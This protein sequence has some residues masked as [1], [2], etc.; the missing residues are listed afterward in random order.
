[1]T[2]KHHR[3]ARLVEVP[4]CSEQY[5]QSLPL[6]KSET[7]KEKSLLHVF[8][9]CLLPKSSPS[10]CFKILTCIFPLTKTQKRMVTF[11]MQMSTTQI[12]SSAMYM[13][14][15]P[16]CTFIFAVGS[17]MMLLHLHC[18]IWMCS[19]GSTHILSHRYLYLQFS[20]FEQRE[21]PFIRWLKSNTCTQSVRKP[22]A[23]WWILVREIVHPT[24]I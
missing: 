9:F 20:L 19:L 12:H 1:M 17:N 14:V 5:T 21:L 22:N 4:P 2:A 23:I 11:E 18:E 6:Y 8:S 15:V 10:K 16:A 24:N 7:L 13:F 3:V